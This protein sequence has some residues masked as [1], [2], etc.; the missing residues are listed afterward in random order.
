V[1]ILRLKALLP[2]ALALLV[3]THL[4]ACPPL[5]SKLFWS[6]NLLVD[7]SPVMLAVDALVLLE[8]AIVTDGTVQMIVGRASLLTASHC[9][10]SL[11]TQCAWLYGT[12][13][14]YHRYT[15]FKVRLLFRNSS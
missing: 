14:H 5:N 4:D 10:T 9:S 1:Q 12:S 6:Y 2:V 15:K 13:K 11:L 3:V 7:G 8:D